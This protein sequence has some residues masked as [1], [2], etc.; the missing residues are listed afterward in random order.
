MVIRNSAPANATPAKESK[1]DLSAIFQAPADY[2]KGE[3]KR[4]KDFHNGDWWLN[5]DYVTVEVAA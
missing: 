5:V 4:L 2:L 3:I 1:T